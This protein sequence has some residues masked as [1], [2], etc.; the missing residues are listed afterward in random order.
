VAIELWGE[1][2]AQERKLDIREGAIVAW[3]DS[4]LAFECALGRARIECDAECD[5]SEAARQDYQ[6]RIHAFTAGC[7]HSFN[8]DRIMEER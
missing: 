3:E 7:R 6:A 1:L 8:F 2:L 4:L 5:Q